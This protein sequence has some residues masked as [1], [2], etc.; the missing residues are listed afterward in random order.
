MVL[1]SRVAGISSFSLQP[2]MNELIVVSANLCFW[3]LIY[4]IY[5]S[6]GPVAQWIRHLTTN[7]G[8]PGSSPARVNIFLPKNFIWPAIKMR[9]RVGSNHQPFG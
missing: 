3:Y 5:A 7:Q 6:R 2:D 8:I 1:T 9:P 4:H